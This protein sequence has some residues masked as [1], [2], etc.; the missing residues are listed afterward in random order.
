MSK[1]ST[2][3]SD[4][5]ISLSPVVL[6]MVVCTALPL[7][8]Y[9]D[10]QLL[11]SLMQQ[12]PEVLAA[13]VHLR[14]DPKRGAVV[15]F[16]SA[17]GC[18]RCHGVGRNSSP[19]GPD[20][21]T[22]SANVKDGMIDG[23]PV[24]EHI[25]DSVLRPSHSIRKGFETVTV[26]TL[27]GQTQSGVVARQ[28][29]GEIV[30]RDAADLQKEITI[31]RSNIDE[32]TVSRTS[33]M[34]EGLAGA[35]FDEGEFYCLV[36]YLSE[37]IEGGIDRQRLLQPSDDELIVK[38]DSVGLNHAGILLSLGSRDLQR[39]REIFQGHCRNCHGTAG[40]TP[41]LPSARAFGKQPLK[42]GADPYQMLLTLTRGNGLMSPMQHLSPRERY[43]VIHFIREELMKPAN[44]SYVAI[45]EEY[46]QS[47][48]KGTGTGDEQQTG[49]RDFGPVLGSQLGNAVNNALTYRLPDD[50]TVSYDLHRMQIADAWAGGFLNLSETQHY[51]QRGERMPRVDGDR[52]PGLNTWQWAFR[53]SFDIPA[54]AK[55]PRGPVNPE[56]M[57][58]FGHYLHGDRAVMSY[59]IQGRRI[60]ETVQASSDEPNVNERIFSGSVVTL[61]HTLRIE[62]GTEPLMLTVAELP[63]SLDGSA[64]VVP[65]DLV[66]ES[67]IGQS[68]V[69]H[70]EPSR[71]GT[72]VPVSDRTA[73]LTAPP[74]RSS[75]GPRM[76]NEAMHVVR[77][78]E[79]RKLDLGTTDRTVIVR[80]RTENDG[81]LVAS[82][83]DRGEWKPDGK[84]LFV[85]GG[86]LVF[87]IGWVGALV[88]RI[89]VS[90]GKWHTAALV[91]TADE[92]RL[93]VDGKLDGVRKGFRRDPVAGHVLKIGATATNFGGDFSGEL[94][95]VTVIDSAMSDEALA[96]QGNVA[97][98]PPR[99]ALFVWVPPHNHP[100]QSG[101]GTTAG[102]PRVVNAAQVAGDVE[103]LQ[104][105]SSFEDRIVL[106]IP[107]SDKVQLIQI[108]RASFETTEQN[109]EAWRGGEISLPLWSAK[110]E[111]QGSVEDLGQLLQG[112]P[113]RWP[114]LLTVRGQLG[115]S[116]N[117]YALDS[118]PVPFENPWNSWL[119]TS[120][121][122]FFSDGRAVVTTH[123]GDVFIISG[124][125]ASLR[126]V[127]WKRFAAGLFEPF[128]VRVVNDTIY[129]TCRD[130]LKRLH[131]FDDNGEA[132]FVEAFWNDDDVSCQFHAYN[133]D[134]QTDSR[135]NF[136]F[137]KAGQYT[138][139]HRP[140][141]IMKIPPQG[142][143][144]EVVAWGLRTPN[145][146]GKL[147]DDRFTVSDNQG[148]WMPAGKISLIKDRG[149]YG[150][151]P[152][153]DEQEQWLKAQH[154][155]SLPD[156]FD[157]PMIWL[158]QDV[159]NSC[160]GQIWVD[161]GRFGPLANRLIHSSY[162]KGWLYYL[163]LQDV[164]GMTQA[165]VV[166]L[167]H[168]W[169]AGVMRLR[170]H[171]ADG[172][173]YGVGL[174][175]WQ[176]PRDGKDGCFQRLRYTADPVLMVEQTEVTKNGLRITFSFDLDEQSLKNADS[177]QAEMWNYLWS[178]RYGSDQFSVR[179]PEERH[180]DQ[181]EV[182]DARVLDSRTVEITMPGLQV[183]DQMQ[184][185]MNLKSAGGRRYA[186]T[187][188]MT[189]HAIPDAD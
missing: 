11:Q 98:R 45:D 130:G 134:L 77:A 183:C 120:A 91:V 29:D 40:D 63:N 147:S 81:T 46:L 166:P 102:T 155:G 143:T 5:R 41:T 113:T 153:N 115:E 42:F 53:G 58:Y 178:K 47:L 132:D 60:L 137:A 103:G 65:T 17:A 89:P 116:I 68:L 188:W 78:E 185:K 64:V 170:V 97:E 2:P 119:R 82:T 186:E 48:P 62:P 177:W 174:S 28:A 175:G 69:G 4:R 157:E 145:G 6:L 121:L 83:P 25:V 13:K 52:I 133:F 114:Q 32:M 67:R 127:R 38:D 118:I 15:F 51:R 181:V 59:A 95:W 96:S 55:P 156:A 189:I 131:D 100:A 61:R 12:S 72:P 18:V 167:P 8:G 39:G 31:A 106:G 179:R 124:I 36:K 43:Q 150:N 169:D 80:F 94:E 160:G 33:M 22:L 112:G 111:P 126:Q 85:R 172:Q 84:T 90:D 27:D 152:I 159:D 54:D 182:T 70:P 146:M 26:L 168:Q 30:L 23:R 142:G 24:T 50:I 164:D 49:E 86:R 151:M 16:K 149:F 14:G 3:V 105:I 184:L 56:R 35:L 34:P 101:S 57:Q 7:R 136:W 73:M 88:G 138:N 141:S 176:G 19:L 117:G 107:A 108:S 140:G 71:V 135:G 93:Y 122:D 187:I 110:E 125:D 158:P 79:A 165:S 99:K 87:D 20:F 163:A 161:D 109:I 92:T 75:R 129:V 144:A 74:D 76:S 173:L 66:S 162:G 104:W 123:G 21:A 128:G 171:P 44:P 154:G 148:P 37:V 139:H 9:A 1:S 10:E 180:H